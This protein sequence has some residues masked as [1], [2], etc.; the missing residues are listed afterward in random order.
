MKRALLL[1]PLLALACGGIPDPEGVTKDHEMPELMKSWQKLDKGADVPSIAADFAAEAVAAGKTPVVYVGAGWCQ[2]CVAY[3]AVLDDPRMKEAHAG[4]RI[5]E[6]DMDLH[7]EGLSELGVN[8]SGIPHW[9]ILDASGK[10]TGA[11]ITGGAWGDN[12]PE[13]MAPALLGF[14]GG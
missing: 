2:P 6:A 1:L 10:S 8:P 3:K 12:T 9:E 7:Y 11:V 14:W 13:N 4:V 5:L